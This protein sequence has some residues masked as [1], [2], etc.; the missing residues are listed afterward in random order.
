M[1][2][3]RLSATFSPMNLSYENADSGYFLLFFFFF[4]F[5]SFTMS[6]HYI[7]KLMGYH[8]CIVSDKGTFVIEVRELL[9]NIPLYSWL[10]ESNSNIL[11]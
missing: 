9:I 6:S 1:T 3:G 7:K 2:P 10:F 11:N 8:K 5:R 4:R